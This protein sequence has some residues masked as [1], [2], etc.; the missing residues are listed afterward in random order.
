M[1]EAQRVI[2]GRDGTW[3]AGWK[4][5]CG[6]CCRGWCRNCLAFDKTSGR[7]KFLAGCWLS[8]SG[9]VAGTRADY[10][11]C[12]KTPGGR[13]EARLGPVPAANDA[14]GDICKEEWLGRVERGSD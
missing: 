11:C 1:G 6:G 3:M 9:R 2:R 7:G 14:R 13:R 5:G 8:R 4:G 10:V 12:A